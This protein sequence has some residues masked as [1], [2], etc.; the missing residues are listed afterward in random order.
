MVFRKIG[1][2]G[3]NLHQQGPEDKAERGKVD[4]QYDP[5]FK[6]NL[7]KNAYIYE[8]TL[9]THV[10]VKLLLYHRSLVDAGVKTQTYKDSIKRMKSD[11]DRGPEKNVARGVLVPWIGA[12]P[13]PL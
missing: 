11:T 5:N 9:K 12:L 8:G 1:S 6:C 13:F 3:A 2:S 10:M 4:F 7:C